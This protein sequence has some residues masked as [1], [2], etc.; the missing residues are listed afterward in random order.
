[1]K[2]NQKL[3]SILAI[4]ILILISGFYFL[5]QK[6]KTNETLLNSKVELI[7][8]LEISNKD[9]ATRMVEI[10]TGLTRLAIEIK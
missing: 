7:N 5:N 4:N 2:E 6:L 8:K 10:D 1:M 3:L 9:L